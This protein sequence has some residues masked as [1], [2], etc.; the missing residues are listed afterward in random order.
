MI[1]VVFNNMEKAPQ[2][3]EKER[4]ILKNNKSLC[5]DDR[6]LGRN[7]FMHKL[8]PNFVVLNLYTPATP[9][10]IFRTQDRLS[11]VHEYRVSF[12]SRI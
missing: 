6:I 4:K 7:E 11:T 8:L 5:I 2:L 3:S 12:A 9:G 1:E 10:C